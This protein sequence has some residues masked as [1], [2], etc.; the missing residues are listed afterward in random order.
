M[1]ILFYTPDT[2]LQQ[3]WLDDLRSALP[4]ADIRL[5]QAGDDAPADYAA[6]WKPVPGILG[7]RAGLKAVFNLGAGVDAVLQL[8]DLPRHIP[9]IRIDDGGMAIQMAE[10][11]TY[12]VLQ[13]FRRFDTYA[14]QAG[15]AHWNKLVPRSKADCRIGILGLGV[16]GARIAES[17]L[18][19]DFPVHGWSRTG[20][21]VPGIHSFAGNDALDP[22]LQQS[23]VLVCAL[24]L[25]RETHQ[26]LARKTLAALP[27]GAYVINIARGEHIVDEDLVSLIDSH[28][29]SG[30]TL[31]AF[32]VEPLPPAHPFWHHP[33]IQVTPHISA[34]TVRSEAAQQVAQ[35]IADLELGKP[36]KG[37]VDLT[38]GY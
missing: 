23:D 17:L 32:R 30:A 8:A 34:M 7:Q 6:V 16:L 11:V 22:F 15:T 10:Y 25:T 9:L 29:L 33:R 37:I 19:F 12:A 4:S 13:H 35:K 14:L 21:H 26:I 5:W 38:Q 28:H 31:D 24:P 27:Q 20:K 2:H 36:V 1:R 3:A 18:H